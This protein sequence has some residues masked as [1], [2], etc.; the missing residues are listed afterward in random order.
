MNF[1]GYLLN[2]DFLKN[3]MGETVLQDS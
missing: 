3:L 1:H 2:F